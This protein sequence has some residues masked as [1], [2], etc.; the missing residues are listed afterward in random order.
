[1]RST[2]RS[3]ISIAESCARLLEVKRAGRADHELERDK[4]AEES[5]PVSAGDAVPEVSGD[6]ALELRVQRQEEV[7][8]QI[9]SHLTAEEGSAAARE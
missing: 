4:V 2:A 8:A 3:E 9:L 5:R 1:M 6:G 7:P